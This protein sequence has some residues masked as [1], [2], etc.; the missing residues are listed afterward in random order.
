[1]RGVAFGLCDG[2]Q[3]DLAE[4]KPFLEILAVFRIVFRGDAPVEAGGV[5]TEKCQILCVLLRLVV[6]VIAEPFGHVFGAGHREKDDEEDGRG[7][8]VHP[9]RVEVGHPAAAHIFEGKEAGSPNQVFHRIEEFPVK[10]RYVVE[11]VLDEVPNGFFW[12]EVLLAAFMAVA[13]DDLGLAVQAV[14]FLSFV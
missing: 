11:E 7:E 5:A 8:D 2:G 13:A 6:L 3:L 9:D 1:M 10:V 4:G 14:L 12:F